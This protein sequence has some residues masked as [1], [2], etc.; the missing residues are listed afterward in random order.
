MANPVHLE[1]LKQGAELW[2]RWRKLR[3]EPD[4]QHS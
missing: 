3:A 4:H 1:I 2:N